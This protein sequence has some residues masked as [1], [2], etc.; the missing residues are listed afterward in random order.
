MRR[1]ALWL[2]VCC[3]FPCAMSRAAVTAD[4]AKLETVT[5]DGFGLAD[6]PAWDGR[7][8]LYVPDVRGGKLFRHIPK[9]KKT[10]VLLEEAGRI[11]ATFY[12]RGTLYLSDNG[13]A[14]IAKLNGK[15]I[16]GLAGH[17]PKAKPPMRPSS[18]TG[19]QM[20]SP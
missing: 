10:Q 18:F 20:A 3:L 16:V 9:Q 12:A 19:S 7:W 13:N 15:E 8:A 4:G 1:I 11:S 5:E 17:D 14:R 6:G 2:V